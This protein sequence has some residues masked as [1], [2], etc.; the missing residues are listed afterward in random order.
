VVI[1]ARVTVTVPTPL[2]E[3]CG[4]HA[5][6]PVTAS[7]VRAVLDELERGHPRLY[8]NLCDETGACGA[9]SISS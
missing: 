6:L 5:D 2:R 3:Y 9:T 7:N 8:R 1:P 4:G